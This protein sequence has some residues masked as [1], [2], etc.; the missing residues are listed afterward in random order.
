M[1]NSYREV[2]I[3]KDIMTKKSIFAQSNIE[4]NTS[5]IE[6]VAEIFSA[7]MEEEVTAQQA[8]AILQMIISLVLVIF[9]V[10]MPIIIRIV[11]MV[12]M[13]V[14]F[15]KCKNAGIINED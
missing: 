3:Q 13:L 14:S 6:C 8:S 12:W 7:V 2:L 1:E 11:C 10:E 5:L 9:P 4:S 15:V